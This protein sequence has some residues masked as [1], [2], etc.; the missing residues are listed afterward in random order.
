MRG[1]ELKSVR[2]PRL[3]PCLNCRF[4]ARHTLPLFGLKNT[5]L[6]EL[7]S[8]ETRRTISLL[9]H[10]ISIEQPSTFLFREVDIIPS[11]EDSIVRYYYGGSPAGDELSEKNVREDHIYTALLASEAAYQADQRWQPE[12]V[13]AYMTAYSAWAPYYLYF[14][15]RGIPVINVTSTQFDLSTVNVNIP[16][17]YF[18]SN[19]FDRFLSHRDGQ[20]LDAS[21]QLSLRH[22]LDERFSG[23]AKIFENLGYF[24]KMQLDIARELGIN[25]KK[26]NIFLFSNIFWDVGLSERVGLFNGVVDW[27]LATIEMVSNNEDID[28]Y[29]KPHPG[30][31]YDSSP[32]LQ[33]VVD[34]I[35]AAYPDL[36]SNI[37][38]I[39]PERKI[40]PY[41]LAPFA[42]LVIVYNGTLGIEMMLQ[43]VPV[44]VCGPSP[45][46][47]VGLG[48]VPTDRESYRDEILTRS[49][50][51][52]PDR[53]RLALFAYFYFVKLQI[54]WNLTDQVYGANFD[55]YNF[56][57]LEDLAPG[58]DAML[59]HL[60]ACILTPEL[61]VVEGW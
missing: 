59:D 25:R 24:D 12:I 53:D 3:D 9:A 34:H 37:R 5:K 61:A 29:I 2:T 21:E 55:G 30:E 44:V 60:C 14:E 42:D 10:Q 17:L 1:C 43:G 57:S 31:N 54:P 27:V 41:E 45:Y 58:Q 38:I 11:V 16:E 13:Y 28:L 18:S 50:C 40:S 39:Q 6:D 48:S 20:P 51:V 22:V 52:S 49:R 36:P 19:R 8:V 26:R 47:S 46:G 23:K 4:N 35:R 32:S 15:G 56:Q 7:V 33:G